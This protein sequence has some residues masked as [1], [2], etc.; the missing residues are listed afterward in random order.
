MN[1]RSFSYNA[2]G[3]L[4]SATNP[5]S[6]QTSY[7]YDADGNLAT[8]T[9]AR[10]LTIT[11][12]YDALNR[13]TGKTYSDS[14]PPVT[15][16]YDQTSAHGQTLTNT[17]GRLSSESTAG[18][19][20]TAAI[21]SYDPIGRILN[22]S[23]QTPGGSAL[24]AVN[25]T[26]DLVGNMLTSSVPGAGTF[27]NT[28]N[29]AS[30]LT[31]STTPFTGNQGGVPTT[32]VSSAHYNTLGKLASQSL[33]NGLTETWGYDNRERLAS[34]SAN[35]GSSN[36]YS[37]SLSYSANGNVMSSNDSVNGDWV[38]GYDD[39]NRLTS[40][41]FT[42]SLVHPAASYSYVYDRFGN[43]WQQNVTSGS[44]DM[45]SLSFDASNHITGSGAA[46][47]AAGNMTYDGTNTYTYD[48]EGRI[49]TV[50]SLGTTY[51]Y[52]AEGRRVAI[53]KSTSGWCYAY[54]LE[55]H[56][57]L[58]YVCF[59][60][61]GRVREE[62]YVSGRHL[63]TYTSWPHFSHQDWLA[64]DRYRTKPTGSQYG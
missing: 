1:A 22:N 37:Y 44:G 24:Q 55:G 58:E 29:S 36:V 15:Y 16:N 23:Q 14:T 4:T 61:A 3:E 25:Y 46:Y 11:Y 30:R 42:S 52:D 17:I 50:P 10:N 60:G 41:S 62:Y 54:D 28:Y 64:S 13:L 56:V 51:V 38:Y 2:L 9:D 59:N 5:E 40:S 43:R 34:Y 6:G 63:I 26:Y 20:A 47:D 8:K 12:A 18:T 31:G 32:L 21:F 7:T 49:A 53:A 19:Y 27:T 45:S 48:A 57:I 39:F 33:G 35:N